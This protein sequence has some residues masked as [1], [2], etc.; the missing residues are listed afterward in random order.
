MFNSYRNALTDGTIPDHLCPLSLDWRARVNLRTSILA[1]TL[2]VYS[3]R[4]VIKNF[5]EKGAWAYPGT[6]QFFG[7]SLLSQERVK[8]RTSNFVC[9]FTGSIGLSEQK[10]IKNVGKSSREC[11]QGLTKMS[12][13]AIYRAHRAVIF[14]I[15]QLSC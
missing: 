6:A 12:R 4:N 15:A 2:T 11:S 5:G 14:A 7:N 3:E 8:L 13:A 10:S 1:D 9:I